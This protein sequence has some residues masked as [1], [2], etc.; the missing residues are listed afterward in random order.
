MYEY[1]DETINAYEQTKKSIRNKNMQH[2]NKRQSRYSL[3][4][5][6]GL[7]PIIR[8]KRPMD[9]ADI[10]HVGTR[11][12]IGGGIGLLAGVGAIAVAA[13]AGE[14]IIGGVVTK[15]SGIVGGTLGLSMGINQ[16]KKRR[17]SEE[18][19]Y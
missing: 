15:I 2:V 7:T 10:T 8:D 1:T 11:I 13:S 4:E 19:Q 6:N 9:L 14:I 3:D 18:F 12:I 16:V 17:L 5:F